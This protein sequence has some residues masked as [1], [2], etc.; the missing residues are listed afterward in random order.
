LHVDKKTQLFND[1][2]NGTGGDVFNWIALSE[3]LDVQLDKSTRKIAAIA[4]AANFISILN[5]ILFH[6]P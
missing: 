1:F 4:S 5:S 3:G 2:A 6:L